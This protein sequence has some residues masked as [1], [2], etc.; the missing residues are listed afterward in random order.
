M[1]ADTTSVRLKMKFVLKI[2]VNAWGNK[3]IIYHKI[4]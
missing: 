3:M 1:Q 2:M 4:N